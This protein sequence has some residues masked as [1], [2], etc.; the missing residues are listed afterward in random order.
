MLLECGGEMR[1][2]GIAEHDGH[3]GDAKAFFV[4]EVA[5]MFHSL[6]LVKIED[7]RPEHFF[8]SFLQVAFVDSYFAAEFPDGQGFPDMPQQDLARA[9]DLLAIRFVGEEF[10]LEAFRFFF[11]DHAF[12]AVKQ[13]DL[14]LGI[15]EDI[16]QAVGIG[17]IEQR[18]KH[19]PGPA[20]KRQGLGEGAGM[21]EIKEVFAEGI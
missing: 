18:F 8:K 19:Q 16:F 3:F 9:D 12:E 6:A 21:S 11:P 5:G 1:D 17:V 20:A 14:A 15:D 2:G 7:G 4:K 13:Q 10:T